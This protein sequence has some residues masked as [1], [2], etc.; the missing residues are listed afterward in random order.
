[1]SDQSDSPDQDPPVLQPV[2]SPSATGRTPVPANELA[3]L[4]NELAAR[5]K[6]LAD[7]LLHNAMAEMEAALFDKVSNELKQQLPQ[8]IHR[9]VSDYLTADD[10][11]NGS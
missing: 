7:T 11:E 10:K 1:M 3:G 8:L 5:T 6:D 9:I 2:T 4:E